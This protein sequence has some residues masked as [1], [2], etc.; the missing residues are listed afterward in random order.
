VVTVNAWM[1]TPAGFTLD[2]AGRVVDVDPVGAMLNPSAPGQVLHMV[3]AAWLATGWGVAAIHAWLLRS[4]PGHPFHRKGLALGLLLAGACT[5]AQP[6]TGHVIAEATAENQPVKLAALEARWETG[7]R[8]AFTLG[9]WPDEAREETRWGL[10]IPA[11]LSVLAYG[12]PDAVVAGL[13]EVPRAERPPV[14]VVHA[15]YQVML[16]TAGA[17]ALTTVVAAVLAWR[18]RGVPEDRWFLALVIATGPLGMLG[19]E[20][21]WTATEVGRQPW[22][23]QGVLRTADAVTPMP[24]LG[25]P[26][27]G[28]V[29]LYVFLGGACALLLRRQF[30][31]SPGVARPGAP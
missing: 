14:A 26:L 3:V 23:V 28:F 4:A 29:A 15:A 1:N 22:V 8:A 16:A 24:G 19:V 10:E 6:L 21:G 18:R 5:L 17:M 2:A 12:D 7:P 30:L 20:A 11:L 31:H 9:G 27:V 25:V 13:S